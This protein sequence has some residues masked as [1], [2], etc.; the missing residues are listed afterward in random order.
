MSNESENGTV[1]RQGSDADFIRVW[2]GATSTREAADALGLKPNS[3]RSRAAKLRK[4]LGHYEDGPNA[5]KP[6]VKKH[7]RPPP[8][9]RKARTPEQIEEL[10]RIAMESYGDGE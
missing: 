5:G 1:K 8:P 2:N 6:V 10:R 7:P 4:L 9:G 3:A